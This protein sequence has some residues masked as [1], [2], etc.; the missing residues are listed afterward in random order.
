MDIQTTRRH[1]LGHLLSSLELAGL[2]GPCEQAN[3]LGNIVTPRRL[4]RML[5]GSHIDTLIARGLEYATALPRG[6]IDQ[7]QHLS[8]V[9]VATDTPCRLRAV[10]QARASAQPTVHGPRPSRAAPGALSIAGSERTGST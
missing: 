1:N 2:Q 9:V 7:T 10:S 5:L 3:A 6:W 4:T 8:P